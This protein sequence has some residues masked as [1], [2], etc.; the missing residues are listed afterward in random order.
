[1]L[2]KCNL[3]LFIFKF[4]GLKDVVVVIINVVVMFM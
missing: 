4:L 1:M 3:M 2:I